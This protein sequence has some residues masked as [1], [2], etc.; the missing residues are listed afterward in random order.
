MR[1]T[2]SR[3]SKL[4]ALTFAALFRSVFDFVVQVAGL[5]IAAELTQ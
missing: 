4:K 5:M 3:Q 1:A 2:A